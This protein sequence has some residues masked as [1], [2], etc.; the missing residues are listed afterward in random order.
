MEI[1]RMGR[2]DFIVGAIGFGGI[3][4]Q[5]L[6]EEEAISLIKLAK[7][8]GINFIDTARGYT[9]SEEL[10]GKG[11]EGNREDW[12]VATKSMARDY[13]SMKRD[14]EI[15][16]KNLR[17]D[18][19]D[20]YQFHLVKTKEDFDKIM[21]PDGAY[22]ALKEAQEAGIIKEIGIT[23]HN[24][25]VLEMTVDTDYFATIQFPY[26]IVENQGEELF[27]RAHE[28]N[29]GVIVMKPLAG[30]ALTEGDLALRYIMENP[31]VSVI[32]PGMDNEAQV[33]ENTKV[34][35]SFR[36]LNAD[37]K[38]K[39]DQL[40]ASLGNQFCRRCGYCLP[41]PQGIDIPT[42]IIMEGYYTRYDLKEWAQERYNALPIK[43]SDCVLCGACEPR[44]PYDLPIR[45]IL[46]RI[47]ETFKG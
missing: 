27:R 19:I 41:C 24:I 6:S 14:I 44:C 47:K 38:E 23:S 7:E 16:L 9:I 28:R 22:R 4:L 34:G 26:N 5:R 10:I 25:E 42:N 18:Y 40:K 35:N 29:I 11:L 30:G 39:L 13:I 36:P 20:L 43:A 2:T 45:D 1:R 32:I 8:E 37:E 46:G 21:S 12:I 15:S 33:M 3:P 31:H 17:T